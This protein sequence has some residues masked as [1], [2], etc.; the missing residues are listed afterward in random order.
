[1]PQHGISLEAKDLILKV[2]LFV[3]QSIEN[4][5]IFFSYYIE[6]RKSV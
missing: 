3:N 2:I 4:N 6:I 1:M 5:Y